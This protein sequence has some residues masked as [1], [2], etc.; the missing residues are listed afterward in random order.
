MASIFSRIKKKLERSKANK[1]W[2]NKNAYLISKGA[3][4]GKGTRLNCNIDAFG[5]EPYLITVGEKCLFAADIHLITHDGGVAM[6]NFLD[7]FGEQH[8]DSIAP[9]TIGDKVYIGTG[10]YV[11]PGVTI[12]SNV[13]I[14]AGAIVTK[15]IPDNVVAVGVPAKPIE[16]IDDYC[17]H[18]QEKGKLFPTVGMPY[19]QKRA[20]FE[21]KFSLN[22][23]AAKAEKEN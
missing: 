17:R 13:I 15:D 4:I 11:M 14:G 12:G 2:A 5:S 10:A 9:I 8:M 19:E 3:V 16:S 6:L 22:K 20:Y 1:N 18:L 21:E 7:Y 23:K